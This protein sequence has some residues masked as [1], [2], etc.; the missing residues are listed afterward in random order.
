MAPTGT[1]LT[2]NARRLL[3]SARVTARRLAVR[4]RAIAAR[5]W[6][7]LSLAV[8][9]V[10][11]ALWLVRDQ[12][13]EISLGAL[14]SALRATP[15]YAIG[16]SVLFTAGSFACLAV[17]EHQ[18]LK[19]IGRPQPPWRGAVASFTSNAIS[20]VM[21]FGVVSGT[22]VRLRTYAFARLKPSQIA[23]LVVLL[24]GA[25]FA[26][27]VVALGMSLLRW[28][29][30]ALVRSPEGWLILARDLALLAPIALWFVLFRDSGKKGQPARTILDR[31]IALA[32]G[33]GDWVFSGA[34]L[35]V[36]SWFVL[37]PRDL[38]AFDGFMRVFCL[39]SLIGS[40]AGVPGGLGVLEAVM[41]GLQTR[42][43]HAHET[44]AALI[45]YRAIYFLGPLAVTLA[46][47]TASQGAKLT[48]RLARAAR[49]RR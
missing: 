9:A 42:R 33:L 16:L 35:F 2:R 26:S 19:V 3:R 36:L 49:D 12:L 1:P 47:E 7:R 48:A 31:L 18:A 40:V 38:G 43:H 20:I 13:E 22:A 28:L 46:G 44:A 27:G 37:S 5:P 24:Q 10:G 17:V 6:V 34:A 11:V 32:A 14:V 30:R 21:G 25:T 8:V 15:L 39:G 45:L 4:I 29:P 23:R 41:L